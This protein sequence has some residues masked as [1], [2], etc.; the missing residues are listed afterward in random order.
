MFCPDCGLF[1][2]R[3][4]DQWKFVQEQ[5]LQILS[6]AAVDA[7]EEEFLRRRAVLQKELDEVQSLQVE[8]DN[9]EQG[10][11]PQDPEPAGKD[12]GNDNECA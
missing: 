4:N 9:E 8:E 1:T 10:Q 5:L 7:K 2:K 11:E 3:K 6:K 12:H